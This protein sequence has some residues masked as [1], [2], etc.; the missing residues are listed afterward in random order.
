MSSLFQV[1]IFFIDGSQYD[2][3]DY[4][5]RINENSVEAGRVIPAEDL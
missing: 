4:I 1:S 3:H 5:N 2:R